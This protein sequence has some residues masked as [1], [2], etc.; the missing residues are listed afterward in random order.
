MSIIASFAVPHPPL[1]VPEIGKGNEKQIEK[2]TES[3]ERVAKEIAEIK[4][5]TIIIS[6]PHTVYL[7]DYFYLSSS[8][9]KGS[10]ERFGSPEVSFEEETDDELVTEIMNIAEQ[11]FSIS[12]SR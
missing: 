3:Y 12:S 7:K 4:P 8:T 6:S 2:T 10:F 9:L 5:E 11:A 1:I